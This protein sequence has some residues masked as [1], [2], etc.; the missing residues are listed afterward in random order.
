[1]S[2]APPRGISNKLYYTPLIIHITGSPDDAKIRVARGTK[3]YR[4]ML[5][6]SRIRRNRF[7]G[8]QVL[9][10][11]PNWGGSRNKLRIILLNGNGA[12]TDAP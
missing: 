9:T 4:D 10:S 1:M 7:G 5:N 2:S 8:S 3:K 11:I 12:K 6:R